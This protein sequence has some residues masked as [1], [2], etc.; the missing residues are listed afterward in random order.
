MAI[1]MHNSLEHIA[2]STE[3]HY[4][5]RISLTKLMWKQLFISMAWHIAP[6]L[7]GSRI[8]RR[9]NL[10]L[11]NRKTRW[12]ERSSKR[13]L[14]STFG[15]GLPK[16]TCLVSRHQASYRSAM[17]RKPYECL[18][19]QPSALLDERNA[20]VINSRIALLRIACRTQRG[21][22]EISVMLKR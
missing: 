12:K 17:P 19:F 11:E 3:R 13:R 14:R 6:S 22:F 2:V 10:N 8:W 5:C 7:S 9:E 16:I 21:E 1:K 15:T 4:L 20:T 18:T